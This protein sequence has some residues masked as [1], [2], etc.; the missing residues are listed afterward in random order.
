MATLDTIIQKDKG[1]QI[2]VI[3]VLLVWG[4]YSGL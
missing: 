4:D 3:T 1:Y 2:S